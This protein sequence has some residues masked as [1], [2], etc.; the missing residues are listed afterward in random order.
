MPVEVTEQTLIALLVVA[1]HLWRR[2]KPVWFIALPAVM[3][4]VIPGW[5]LMTDVLRPETG[6]LATKNY[7]LVAIA[8]GVLALQLWIIV[9]AVLIWRK[10]RGVI[11]D[12]FVPL[13]SRAKA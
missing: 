4:L 8:L 2:N 1:F 3:M 6:Y 13:P 7:L 12:G 10:A 9:E 11:E 5:A